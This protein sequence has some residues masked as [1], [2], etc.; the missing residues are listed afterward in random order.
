MAYIVTVTGIDNEVRTLGEFNHWDR[1][2]TAMWDE[3]TARALEQ[4]TNGRKALEEALHDL[5]VGMHCPMWRWTD[6]DGWTFEIAE[7]AT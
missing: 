1:A 5:N 3:L 7:T 4:T 2:S 6:P